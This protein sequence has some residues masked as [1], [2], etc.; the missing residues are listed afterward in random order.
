MTSNRVLSAS[1]WFRLRMILSDG[2]LD[3]QTF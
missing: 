2:Q 3:D 1:L